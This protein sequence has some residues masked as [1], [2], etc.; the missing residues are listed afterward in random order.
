MKKIA[1]LAS[2]NGSNLQAILDAVESGAITGAAVTLVISDKLDAFALKRAAASN[3]PTKC[4]LPAE[5]S[6][7]EEYDGALV[8]YLQAMQIDLVVLAGFM[9]LL[10]PYFVAAY[11]R[12]IMN[13]HPSLLPAFPGAHGV[14]DALAYGVKVTGCTIHFVDE[15]MDTGPI[16]LQE[17]LTINDHDTMESLQQR[18]HE[19]EHRLYPQAIDLCVRGKIKLEGRRCLIND[20]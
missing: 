8:T 9:R 10:T 17:A 13:I 4:F 11:P 6:T 1:V 20:N 16:I 18:I 7:R 2:G 19:L 15:G 12:Q 5:Y 3:V 14:A